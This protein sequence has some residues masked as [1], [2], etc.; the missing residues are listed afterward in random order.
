MMHHCAEPGC[1]AA[2]KSD[3]WNN[4]KA[5]KLGW[6]MQRNGDSWCPDHVP[7]W[8]AQWREEKTGKRRS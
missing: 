2:H 6:F 7:E 3:R 8:V 1:T 5:Q 4:S